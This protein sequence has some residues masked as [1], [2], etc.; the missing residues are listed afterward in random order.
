MKVLILGSRKL[1]ADSS[2]NQMLACSE[3]TTLCS[4]IG[5]IAMEQKNWDVVFITYGGDE[6]KS[7]FERALT[8]SKLVFAIGDG[9]CGGCLYTNSVIYFDKEHFLRS[10]KNDAMREI[11]QEIFHEV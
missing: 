1:V 11:P 7:L 5:M 3:V 10:A 4:S 8:C 9:T 2:F 6:W